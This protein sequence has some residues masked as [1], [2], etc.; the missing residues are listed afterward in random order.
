VTTKTRQNRT[1][2][3]IG[4][5]TERTNLIKR[6]EDMH[7]VLRHVIHCS[8]TLAV[9]SRT[10]LRM[11]QDHELSV[12]RE[13]MSDRT[14]EVNGNVVSKSKIIQTSTGIEKALHFHANFLACLELRAEAFKQRL[15]NEIKLVSFPGSDAVHYEFLTD[16][17]YRPLTLSL[18]TTAAPP[19]ISCKRHE[20]TARPWQES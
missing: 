14:V 6:Y 9:A 16:G 12:K 8:E 7:E 4:D 3:P 2:V 10:L 19:K 18:R 15:E 13:S 17:L 5:D 20:T 1:K 11:S